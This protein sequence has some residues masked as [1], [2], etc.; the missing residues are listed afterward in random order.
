[1][2][3]LFDTLREKGIHMQLQCP[4]ISSVLAQLTPT[5]IHC[6]SCRFNLDTEGSRDDSAIWRVLETVQMK[7]GVLDLPEKLG[8]CLFQVLY[9]V[10]FVID[11]HYICKK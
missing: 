1:M 2:V 5:V 8:W 7:A 6:V 11:S 9:P 10:Y 4:M 3:L